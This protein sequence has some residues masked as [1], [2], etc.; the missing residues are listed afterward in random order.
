MLKSAAAPPPL[1][2]LNLAGKF[3]IP[4]PWRQTEALQAHLKRRGIASTACWDPKKHE[5]ELEVYSTCDAT[6]VRAALGEW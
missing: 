3:V 4:V 6:R 2:R 5:A 1:A